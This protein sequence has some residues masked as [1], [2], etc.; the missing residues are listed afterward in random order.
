MNPIKTSF[1]IKALSNYPTAHFKPILESDISI[2]ERYQY[3]IRFNSKESKFGGLEIITE[4]KN[5]VQ[6]SFQT[7]TSNFVSYDPETT[8][9]ER[10]NVVLNRFKTNLFELL[11]RDVSL[12]P[13]NEDLKK[14]YSVLP[15]LTE[16]EKQLIL[17]PLH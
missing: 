15:N 9:D 13:T 1:I 3:Q 14:L 8:F 5:L 2:P 16:E 4:I 10:L 7:Y 12:I 17:R 11:C 6:N